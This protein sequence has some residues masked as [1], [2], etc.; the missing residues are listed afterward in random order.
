MDLLRYYH[1][2][3]H[4]T[5]AQLWHQGLHRIAS[6]GHRPGQSVRRLPLCTGDSRV[7]LS[8]WLPKPVS[9]KGGMT[10]S[11]L[12]VEHEPSSWDDASQGDLWRY[13]LNYMDC[14]LQ[15]SM[16]TADGLALMHAFVQAAPTNAVADDP[17]PIS[18]RGINWIKFFTLHPDVPAD[19]KRLLDAFLL[20]QYR[21]LATHVERHLMANHYLENGFSLLFAAIYFRDEALLARAERI[22]L[23]QLKE[24]LLADGAHFELSPMYHCV[25][26][27]RLLDCCNLLLGTDGV[28]QTLRRHLLDGA[29]A[30]LGW[31]ESIVLADGSIPL[32]ND[33]ARSVAPPPAALF[34]YARRLGL[35]WTP[36]KLTASGYRHFVRHGLE[37]IADVGPLGAPCNPGHAHADALHFVVHL[38]GKPFLVDSGTSTYTAGAQR[39]HERSSQAH[40]TVVVGDKSSSHVWGAFRCAERAQ[41]TIIRDEPS[42]LEAIHDGYASDGIV[43][44]R[45]W[46][47]HDDAIEVTDSCEGDTPTPPA[48]YIHL[49]PDVPVLDVQAHHPST[50][51][52]R[53]SRG[54]L[55][56][57]GAHAVEVLQMPLA[58][59]YNRLVPAAVLKITFSHRLTTVV[60]KNDD[61][62][63]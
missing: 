15:P 33:A 52:V 19:E 25:L 5:A 49:A 51:V 57:H 61:N 22:L 20:A 43:V 7:A 28:S 56:I 30:M 11:F 59:E 36:S 16:T 29:S 12:N 62:H 42:L 53:T 24:Q 14:L 13:N 47:I 60:S 34:D 2:L 9:W 6:L 58:E 38:D 37:M 1:T 35:S 21:W 18:L 41:T 10:F 63:D 23:P 27:D 39:D 3:R 48:A 8:P 44:R 31:L 50:H 46:T 54:M 32:L 26:L 40:N 45:R 17:Y 4:L 55:T